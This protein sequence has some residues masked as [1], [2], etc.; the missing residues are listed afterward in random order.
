MLH[1]FRGACALVLAL[2]A[3]P[4]AGQ[5][6]PAI[7]SVKTPLCLDAWAGVKPCDGASLVGLDGNPIGPANPL[8]TTAGPLAPAT[9][10]PLIGSF[11]A[12]AV[13]PTSGAA[14]FAGGTAKAGPF[15]PILGR[16]IA[17]RLWGAGPFS[18]QLFNSDDGGAT[19][20]PLTIFDTPIGGPY[21]SAV[22]S[23][24]T[25]ETV[26]GRTYWLLCT[27]NGSFMVTQ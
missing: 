20:Y 24:I 8:P 27:G 18:C 19:L 10:T 25:S 4:V 3:A 2:L 6:L 1:T 26:A 22:N 12:S 14:T 9:S 17:L 23:A 13:T 15:V 21:T 16:D 11:T 7:P 5:T